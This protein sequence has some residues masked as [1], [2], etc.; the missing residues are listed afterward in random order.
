MHMTN[1]LTFGFHTQE[2]VSFVRTD[3]AHETN[4]LGVLSGWDY[5]KSYVTS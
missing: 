5:K 4:T 2:A 3:Q 1:V